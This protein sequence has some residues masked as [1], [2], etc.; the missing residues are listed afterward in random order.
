MRIRESG[1]SNLLSCASLKES[2]STTKFLYGPQVGGWKQAILVW[3]R[4]LAG[5][6][7]RNPPGGQHSSKYSTAVVV[8][9]KTVKIELLFSSTTAD[10]RGRRRT[11]STCNE[12]KNFERKN[13]EEKNAQGGSRIVVEP[14]VLQILVATRYFD[15]WCQ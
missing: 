13:L 9:R 12:G 4:A 5:P 8:T 1:P 15:G 7:V 11:V 6:S 14:R 3:H 2:C 10:Q